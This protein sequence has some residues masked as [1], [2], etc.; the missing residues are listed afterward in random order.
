[1]TDDPTL[2][3]SAYLDGDVTSDER[4]LVEADPE[5]ASE[6]ERLRQVRALLGDVEPPSI[7]LREEHLATA[8]RAWDRLPAAERTGGS[9]DATP[10]SLIA[11]AS[12]SDR[13]RAALNRRL[14]G[15][16]AAIVVVL[17][18]GIALQN[19][20]TGD[21]SE[22]STAARSDLLDDAEPTLESA[23]EEAASGGVASQS[24][25]G[26]GELAAESGPADADATDD[27][28]ALDT[29]VG[30]AAPPGER[31][32][33]LLQTPADLAVFA[34]ASVGAPVS[35]DVPAATSAPVGGSDDNALL[36]AELP[37]C[38]GADYVVGPAIYGRVEVVV[39]VDEGRR[40]AI[41]YRAV[42]RN[43]VARARL[44]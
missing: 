4:A 17:G 20:S 44:P 2:L 26:A 36:E 40:L 43:E 39:G 41:A 37:L 12:L 19:I 18:G 6:V 28:L 16:A 30:D 24:D 31:I 25:A 1:M 34:A 22:S 15:A 11:P 32:L 3:A 9:S 27:T 23:T 10:R 35:P 21:D 42:D 13:R 33:D 5:L 29:A 8:L 7:S 14:L 38:R